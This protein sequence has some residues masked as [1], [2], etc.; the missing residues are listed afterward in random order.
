LSFVGFEGYSQS[1]TV[2][3]GRVYTI[4]SKI[5]SFGQLDEVVVSAGKKPK[6]ITEFQPVNVIKLKKLSSFL[7][8]T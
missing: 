3:G 6:T 4:G 8:L 5:E 1:V 7:A 2:Q